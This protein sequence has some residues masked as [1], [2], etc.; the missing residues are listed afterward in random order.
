MPLEYTSVS[1]CC[2][3]L[4]ALWPEEMEPALL[5]EG[6]QE[7]FA[8]RYGS[9][10]MLFVSSMRHPTLNLGLG[11]EPQVITLPESSALLVS[12]V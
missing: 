1:L 11:N 3:R 6:F 4:S 12:E 2:A 5:C 10:L 8:L 7:R 9:I